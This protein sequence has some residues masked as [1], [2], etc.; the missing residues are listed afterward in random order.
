MEAFLLV[1]KTVDNTYKQ[2]RGIYNYVIKYWKYD[3][4]GGTALKLA[5]VML[6][7]RTMKHHRCAQHTMHPTLAS[8]AKARRKNS[9]S[10]ALYLVRNVGL[11]ICYQV[12]LQ[13]TPLNYD[14]P[15]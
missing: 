5:Y 3:A 4:H 11:L 9:C 8:V 10:S 12:C 13:T 7:R 1:I 2:V 6:F 15:D 14:A